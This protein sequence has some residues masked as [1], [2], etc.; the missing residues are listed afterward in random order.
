MHAFAAVVFQFVSVGNDAEGV[1]F[2]RELDVSSVSKVVDTVS[3]SDIM[4]IIGALPTHRLGLRLV[5]L[6]P[7]GV[8]NSRMG[9]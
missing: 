7:G 4:D 8:L 1:K 2:L 9:N 5:I 6:Y 3:G